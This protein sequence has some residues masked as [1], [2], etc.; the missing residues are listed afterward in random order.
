ME[1]RLIAVDLDGTLLRSDRTL[2]PATIDAV[3]A[4]AARGLEVVIAS[5]RTLSETRHLL[6]Q[7]PQVRYLVGNTGAF[8]LDTRT[9]T[10]LHF[11]PVPLPL[12]QAAWQRLQGQDM[13]FEVNCGG[14]IYIPTHRLQE[15][16]RF[17]DACGNHTLHET[18]RG[19][20]DYDTWLHNLQEPVT[21]L[22]LYFPTGAIRDAAQANLSDLEGVDL[23]TSDPVDLDMTA[24]GVHKGTGVAR[25][26]EHLGLQREQV[27]AIGDSGNDLGM[28]R[29]AGTAVVM[30]NGSDEAKAL[31][32]RITDTNDNDGVSKVLNSLPG[33]EVG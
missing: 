13:L 19:I 3:A 23:C 31:A 9:D 10:Y 27:M 18:R 11:S 15:V 6:A 8:V 2:S 12:V 5:G 26:A 1:T 28:L 7:L 32:H 17:E 24:R 14:E 20:D 4:A 30:A 29:Y 22:H 33:V 25:L 21:K 16:P